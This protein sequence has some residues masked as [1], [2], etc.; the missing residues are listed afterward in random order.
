MREAM[1][2]R[3]KR[4]SAEAQDDAGGVD[5][6]TPVG[7]GPW[8]VADHPVDDDDPGRAHLGSLSV[9]GRA[10][11][12]L[13]LQV[14]EGSG[15]VA[16]VM[17]VSQDGALEVRPFAASRNHD[18]WADVM[19]QI[20]E[21]IQRQG[22][23]VEEVDGPYGAA[24]RTVVSGQT[25]DGETVQQPA[26]LLG[27]SGPRWLLRVTAFGRPATQWSP[28]GG[29]EQQLADTVVLRGSGPMPPGDP[30]PLQLPPDARRAGE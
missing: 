4:E 17:L 25:A 8:D 14:D 7:R 28:D 1:R 6:A 18:M 10:D 27:V 26:M 22:G 11:T 20:R 23:Q 3:R 21:E 5:T 30:L 12:E 13:R 19:P 16:A 2:R 29:L 15:T 24:L 9:P